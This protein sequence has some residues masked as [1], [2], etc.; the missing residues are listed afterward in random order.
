MVDHKLKAGPD[1]IEVVGHD[2]FVVESI[3]DSELMVRREG[4]D[5]KLYTAI[6][7]EVFADL[8]KNIKVGDKIY[9]VEREVRKTWK[10]WETAL[11]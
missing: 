3:T 9:L 7:C 4:R 5:E 10:S 11:S 2:T 6:P 8:G 1:D